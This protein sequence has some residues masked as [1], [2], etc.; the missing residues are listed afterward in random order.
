VKEWDRRSFMVSTGASVAALSWLPEF[1]TAAPQS[2]DGQ[3]NVAVIGVGRQGRAILS[4]LQQQPSARV[5]AI[6]DI[7][8]R[9]LKSGQRRVANAVAYSD[10]TTMLDGE[11][12]ADAIIIATPTHTH[13]EVAEVCLQA[14]KHVY[15]EAPLASTPDDCAAI[16][17]TAREAG[18][19]F[20]T[21]LQARSNPIYKLARTFFRSD[22]VRNVISMR[23]Q[24]FKKT[25]WRTPSN[26]PQREKL[27][28]WRL[29]PAIT[30]GL[31]GEF[32]THQYDV[33][34]WFLSQYPARVRCAGSLRF[35]DD[36]RTVP[37]T[38]HCELTF[39]DGV[40]LSY[41]ASLASSFES[42]HEVIY[43]SNATLKLAWNA[44][45]MFKEADAPTQGWEVY[46]NRQQFHNDEGITLIADATKLASQGKLKE[47]VALPHPP[48]YYALADFLTSVIHD[49][50]VVCSAEEGMRT[51]TVGIAAHRALVEGK[52]IDI[53]FDQNLGT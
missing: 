25:S 20:Q 53:N 16:T 49:K 45:W 42:Q 48:L 50:P 36:G 27:L 22:A 30:L 31:E 35:Y 15:C 14:G 21:G 2:S 4:Q 3:V 17:D 9:R 32:G 47:G 29:D 26:D 13:R 40:S 39:P 1:A 37:D 43:G 10:V 28:N 11:S 44:G 33:F 52:S 51:T 41:Q 46:A 8:E 18:T 6:C 19:K 34:H 24:Y 5:V 38:I 12:S 7:D 23:A